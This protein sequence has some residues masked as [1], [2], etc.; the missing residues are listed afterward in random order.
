MSRECSRSILPGSRRRRFPRARNGRILMAC[1][2]TSQRLESPRARGTLSS[3]LP[4]CGCNHKKQSGRGSASSE[5]DPADTGGIIPQL[6]G[7]DSDE[8]PIKLPDGECSF[9]HGPEVTTCVGDGLRKCVKEEPDPRRPGRTR[10]TDEFWLDPNSPTRC[11]AGYTQLGRAN[12]GITLVSHPDQCRATISRL[13]HEPKYAP[14]PCPRIA[15]PDV[16]VPWRRGVRIPER[17][18]ATRG[19]HR[20]EKGRECCTAFNV[21]LCKRIKGWFPRDFPGGGGVTG[22]SPHTPTATPPIRLRK[23]G[24]T[25]PPHP[26]IRTPMI[27]NPE[28]VDPGLP[29]EPLPGVPR[30]RLARGTTPR[31]PRGGGCIASMVGGLASPKFP[32]RLCAG[33]SG[34]GRGGSRSARP[35]VVSV[36]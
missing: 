6:N 26:P 17:F 31:V 15:P 30:P 10:R 18:R 8:P 3:T 12:K 13:T 4:E 2:C 27:I 22:G 24:G 36:E 9:T 29:D 35:V 1:S 23:P 14:P 7:V 21:L 33:A 5:R 32:E 11:P 28:G 25:T 34:L 16:C 19:E 20:D